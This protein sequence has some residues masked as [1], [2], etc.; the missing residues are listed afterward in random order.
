MI[1]IPSPHGLPT[2]L[3][4]ERNNDNFCV[5]DRLLVYEQRETQHSNVCHRTPIADTQLLEHSGGSGVD[6]GDR[7]LW[8]VPRLCEL[9]LQ[10]PSLSSAI[11][12]NQRAVAVETF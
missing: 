10:P 3:S 1:C 2:Y 7:L 9:C 4:S 11:A 5:T 12:G 6:H 8:R